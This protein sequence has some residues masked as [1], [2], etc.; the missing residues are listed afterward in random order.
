MTQT[1]RAQAEREKARQRYQALLV[2]WTA[3]ALRRGDMRLWATLRFHML[4]T[5]REG[6]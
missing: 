3:V 6:D 5:R 4:L 1:E 2:K